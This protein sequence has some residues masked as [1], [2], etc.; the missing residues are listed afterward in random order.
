[1]QEAEA[2]EGKLRRAAMARE[3]SGELRVLAA[4]QKGYKKV[5]FNGKRVEK[6]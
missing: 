3:S 5:G 2:W 6:I 4:V 1:M